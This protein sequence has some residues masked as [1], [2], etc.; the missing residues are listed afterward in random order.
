M[1]DRIEIRALQIAAQVGVPDLERSIP[2]RLETDLDLEGDFRALGDDL[3]RTTD[4]AAVSDWIRRACASHEFRLIETLAD[5]LSTGLLADF[6]RVS[7]VTL[8]VRK[9]ILP[10]ARS[11][12]V[13]VKRDRP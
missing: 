11:V 12:A 9:F 8:T 2:Q 1:S 4:Y 13:T 5:H 6:P 10:G 7:S 3:T